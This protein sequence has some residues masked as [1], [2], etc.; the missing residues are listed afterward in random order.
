MFIVGNK[1]ADL[2][3]I[4]SDVIAVKH[5]EVYLDCSYK[6]EDTVITWYKDG[7]QITNTTR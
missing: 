7:A 1:A 3:Y 2:D 4:A 6:E 5:T